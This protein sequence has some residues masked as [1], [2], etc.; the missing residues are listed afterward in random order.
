V[1]FLVSSEPSGARVTYAGRALGTTP[2]ELVVPP[3]AEGRAS[4]ELTFS[5]DGY[6]RAT[7]KAE[8][9]GTEVPFSYKLKKKAGRPKRP[10]SSGYK[11]DP[12]L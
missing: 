5:L 2:L 7:V 9:E 4:A 1:R 3:G 12:Y 8:G 10:G 11:D 6:Q